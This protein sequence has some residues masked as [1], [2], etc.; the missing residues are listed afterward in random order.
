[1]ANPNKLLI[2][3]AGDQEIVRRGLKSL[4]ASKPGGNVGAEAASGHQAITLAGQHRVAP[5]ALFRFFNV[6]GLYAFASE[7]V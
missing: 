5:I 4:I 1:M 3:I 2:L 6:R 7:L